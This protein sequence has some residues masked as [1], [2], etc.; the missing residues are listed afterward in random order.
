MGK[1][2]KLDLRH[3]LS[4]LQVYC[5][6]VDL[7]IKSALA[8][9]L[10]E[11]YEFKICAIIRNRGHPR[12]SKWTIMMLAISLILFLFARFCTAGT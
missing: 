6:L 9:R 1:R 7:G 8:Q 10:G 11:F 5:R 2:D 12:L 4:P 3:A